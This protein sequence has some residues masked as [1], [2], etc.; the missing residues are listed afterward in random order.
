MN[1]RPLTQRLAVLYA[2]VSSDEQERE[3]FSIPSQLKFL[4]Q[5]AEAEGF[6]I[7]A[8]FVDVETAKAAGRSEFGNMVEF[9]QEQTRIKDPDERCRT[10]LVEKTD[11]LY[12]NLKDWV[13]IDEL[14]ID[15]HFVK[16]NSVISPD[17]HSSERFLHGIKVLMAKNYVDNLSEETV[18]GLQEKAE[19][20]IWPLKPSV[21][22]RSVELAGG[23]KGIEPDPD[24]APIIVRLFEWYASGDYSLDEITEMAREAGLT[25][26]RSR[27]PANRAWIHKILRNR[28]YYG[29]FDWKGDVYP[30]IHEPL[31]NR[32]LWQK[33]QATMKKRSEKK[34]RRSKHNFAFSGLI[35]CAHCGCAL[36]GEIQKKKYIYYHCTRAK[37]PC[38]A[39]YVREEVLEEKFTELLGQLQ[40]KDELVVWARDALRESHE[41]EQ[42]FHEEA[43]TRLQ[44]EY[45]R[46][47]RRIEEMYLDK[48]DG[49]VDAAFFDAK[50]EEWREAQAEIH[51]QIEQHTNADRVYM[52]EGL[53]ILELA[54]DAVNLFQKQSAREKRRLL[55]F[56]LSNCTF[57]GEQLAPEFRQPFD[58]IA[59]MA[60]ACATEKAAEANSDDLCQLKGG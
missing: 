14:D 51:R 4:R 35:T 55:R 26:P 38:P 10:I 7:V 9:L 2:R 45:N 8:E 17:S 6:T 43:V 20:G 27:K 13:T 42:T 19:Q 59:D 3:G 33:V 36:V 22:Y 12:R 24:T 47:Q 31:I 29:E 56:V 41:D 46:L 58:M 16:E 37:G 39:P 48:L 40:W 54:Q 57:D 18:K 49:R 5:Y 1:K 44:G 23:K 50:S 11:R 30:A 34:T 60:T 32:E 25:T 53:M 21:G 52:D 15:I 28:I